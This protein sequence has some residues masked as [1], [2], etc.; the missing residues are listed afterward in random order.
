MLEC[1]FLLNRTTYP[2]VILCTDRYTLTFLGYGLWIWWILMTE[3]GK[4]H[5]IV[6]SKKCIPLFSS[7]KYKWPFCICDLHM[8]TWCICFCIKYLLPIRSLAIYTV[9]MWGCRRVQYTTFFLR[10]NRLIYPAGFWYPSW[11]LWL[12]S[13]QSFC[14]VFFVVSLLSTIDTALNTYDEVP[15]IHRLFCWCQCP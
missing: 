9:Q 5:D 14:L 12:F 13:S 2:N 7:S 4:L 6:C 3:F 1:C 15:G 8:V 10:N 11:K